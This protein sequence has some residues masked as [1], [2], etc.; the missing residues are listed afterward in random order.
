VAKTLGSLLTNWSPLLPIISGFALWL[1]A[2]LKEFRWVTRTNELYYMAG[3]LIHFACSYLLL[4][5]FIAWLSL[6]IRR[7]AFAAGVTLWFVGSWMLGAITDALLGE[8]CL[9]VLPLIS[10]TLLLVLACNIPSR[11]EALAAEE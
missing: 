1:P 11:L 10:G 5:V 8:A 3:G 2:L 9:I 7:G 6:R 4:P